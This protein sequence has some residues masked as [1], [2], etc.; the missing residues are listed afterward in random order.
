MED[1][2]HVVAHLLRQNQLRLGIRIVH[3]LHVG[4]QCIIIGLVVP[5]V[6]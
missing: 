2:I 6:A 3:E 1:C 5:V 4:A